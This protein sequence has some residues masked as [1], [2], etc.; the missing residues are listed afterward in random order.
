MVVDVDGCYELRMILFVLYMIFY[1]GLIGWMIVVCGWYLWCFV[2]IYL[3]VGVEGYELFVTQLFFVGGE[4]FGE[5]VVG[6]VKDELVV[7]LEVGEVSY[8]FL[9]VFVVVL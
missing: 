6:V 7:I 8:D 1:D 9:F 3:I 5:D 4:Y 2:Y